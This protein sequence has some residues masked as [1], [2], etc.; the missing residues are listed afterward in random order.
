[1]TAEHM[2]MTFK[3]A[4]IKNPIK[5]VLVAYCNYTDAHGVCWPS[6]ER[7][8]DDCGVSRSTVQRAKRWL[9]AEGLMKTM[10]RKNTKGEPIPNLSRINVRKLKSMARP[11]HDYGD[12]VIAALGFEEDHIPKTDPD[13]HPDGTGVGVTR[14]HTYESD[15]LRVRVTQTQ[16]ESPPDSLTLNEPSK[17]SHLSAVGEAE[18]IAVAEPVDV[19]R[20]DEAS[21]KAT[22]RRFAQE[23]QLIGRAYRDACGGALPPP[24]TLARI[25]SEALGL[26]KLGWPAAHVVRLAAELPAKGYASLAKHAEHNPPAP[27]RAVRGRPAQRE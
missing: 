27:V 6:E 22:S 7:I 11:E 24:R 16:G 5:A 2:G 20:E 3:A 10:R 4:G 26:L 12:D 8:A 23:L 21:P 15:R 17:N 18:P 13:G 14:T 25:K 19:E 9:I 1:M